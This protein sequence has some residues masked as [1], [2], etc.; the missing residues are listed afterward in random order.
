MHTLSLP[1]VPSMWGNL[2]RSTMPV[3]API[4]MV[5]SA[6]VQLAIQTTLQSLPGA[7]LALQRLL[8]RQIEKELGV[9]GKGNNGGRRRKVALRDKFILR[10]SC[11]AGANFGMGPWLTMT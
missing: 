7:L 2:L 10:C 4:S 1:C 3:M 8:K 5:R 11:A 6:A 9:V